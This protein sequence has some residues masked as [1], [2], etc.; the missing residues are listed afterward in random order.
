M[1]WIG[2]LTKLKIV[3]KEDKEKRDA[4]DT[5]NQADSVLHQTRSNKKELGDNVPS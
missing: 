3:Q 4:I 1:R 2:W 5:K